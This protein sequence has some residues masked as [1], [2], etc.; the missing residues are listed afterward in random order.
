MILTAL[1]LLMAALVLV[2]L[3][4]RPGGSKP[5]HASGVSHWPVSFHADGQ[6]AIAAPVDQNVP[7][8]ASHFAARTA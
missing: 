3:T 4:T 5:R 6:L 2:L 1:S 7:D 8:T